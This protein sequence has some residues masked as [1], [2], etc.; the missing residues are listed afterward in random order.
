MTWFT[1][2]EHFFTT[3]EQDV[4]KLIAKI[5]ADVQVIE[6]ELDSGLRWV[7]NNAPAI[8]N[9][10]QGVLTLVQTAGIVSPQVEAAIAMANT[11]VV[12]LNAFSHSL[13]AGQSTPQA[14]VQG[15]VAVKSAQAATAQAAVAAANSKSAA[16]AAVAAAMPATA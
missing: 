5:K 3:T 13:K 2:V 10:I 15:Y 11:A 1:D 12:A 8:A 7:A 4:L 9:D 6:S 16:P 14:L